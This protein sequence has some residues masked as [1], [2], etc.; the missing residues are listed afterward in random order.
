[1]YW[2]LTVS[3]KC[4][5]NRR[6]AIKLVKARYILFALTVEADISAI[7]A[8]KLVYLGNGSINDKDIQ[9]AIIRAI[10]AVGY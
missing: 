9:G 3:N 4:P 10:K 2:Y 5:K 8:C 6:I 7:K 1:M